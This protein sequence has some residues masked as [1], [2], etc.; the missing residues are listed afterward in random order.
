M[1]WKTTKVVLISLMGAALLVSCAD[2]PS[3]GPALPEF[4]AEFR[5]VNAAADLAGGNVMVDGESVG[6]LS[7]AGT[8][9]PHKTY[10][11][12]SR[13]I[14]VAG[15]TVLVSMETDWRGTIY[16]LPLVEVDGEMIRS[17]L[18]VKERRIFDSAET[19]QL[20]LAIDDTTSEMVNSTAIRI[21]NAANSVAELSV[22]IEDADGPQVEVEALPYRENSGYFAL[23]TG[24]YSVLA[25]AGDDTVAQFSTG[26]L[27]TERYTVLMMS[28]ASGGTVGS[29]LAD[30]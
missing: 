6:T 17:A 14:V 8:W 22:Y 3:T 13:E 11:S 18:P 1:S 4:N 15:D 16:M 23:M 20:E 25:V 12:G 29:V 26:A 19:K 9:I 27:G 10:D 5:I 28:T 21:F 24:T 7:G 30:K 2:V